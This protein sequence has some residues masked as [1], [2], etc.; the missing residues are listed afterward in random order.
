M[1]GISPSSGDCARAAGCAGRVAV[2]AY[3]VA[4]QV[5]AYGPRQG[6]MVYIT[7]KRTFSMLTA[8]NGVVILI[9]EG[10]VEVVHNN[11]GG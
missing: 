10:Q 1:H 4:R 6:G 7:Y 5:S 8:T 11:K 2:S 3:L 9:I